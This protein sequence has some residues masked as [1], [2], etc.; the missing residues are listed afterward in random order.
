MNRRLRSTVAVGGIM[1][2]AAAAA[3]AQTSGTGGTYGTRIETQGWL[4]FNWISKGLGAIAIASGIAWAAVRRVMGDEN[5]LKHGFEIIIAG[6][7][8][9]AAKNIVQM[10]MEF[11]G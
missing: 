2:L 4:L 9:F 3:Y 10:L 8:V 7:V 1:L 6:I 11:F 5:A